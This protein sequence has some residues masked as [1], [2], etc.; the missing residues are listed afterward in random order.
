MARES[1]DDGQQL[2]DIAGRAKQIEN[3]DRSGPVLYGGAAHLLR[4]GDDG[5]EIGMNILAPLAD[6]SIG[7]DIHTALIVTK[8][9]EYESRK[10]PERRRV[11][12]VFYRCARRPK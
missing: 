12:P 6:S 11:R 1:R 4:E 9:R 3:P 2:R 8:R 7:P 10:R 5:C